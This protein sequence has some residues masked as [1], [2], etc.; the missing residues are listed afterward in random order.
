LMRVRGVPTVWHVRDLTPLGMVG[1]LLYQRAARVAVISSAVR[2]A[3]GRLAHDTRKCV[4]LPPAVDTVQFHPREDRPLLR[5][6]LGLP[7]EGPLIGMIAQFVRWKRHH[8]F[9]D[10]L[11]ELHGHAWHAVLAGAD[12]HHDQAFLNGLR[13]RINQ[14]PLAGRVTW[15]PWQE[16]AAPLLAA[17][18]LCVLTAEREPFG[19]VLIEAAACGVPAVAMDQAG[20]RDIIVPGE[21]GLLAVDDPL[22]LAA[23]IARMLGDADLRARLGAAAR[24]RVLERFS[25]A[26]HTAALT[27]LYAQV[28]R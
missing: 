6:A 10:A 20:P 26:G 24:A 3:I 2:E 15:L 9:L 21:T 11:T 8:L 5:A 22:A 23:A 19:R 16:D 17:L 18:D 12:L 14:P 28:L 13:D 4:T 1:G 25:L 7:A 27:A